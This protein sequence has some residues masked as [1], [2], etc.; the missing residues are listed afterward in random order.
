MFSGKTTEMLRRVRRYEA[1][2]RKCLV[3]KYAKDLRY[4][5]TV[6]RL[7]THDRY[8]MLYLSLDFHLSYLSSTFGDYIKLEDI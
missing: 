3:I 1:A 6:E 5:S 8:I 2:K 4:D 7:V